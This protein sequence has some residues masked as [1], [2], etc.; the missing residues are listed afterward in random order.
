MR[1]SGDSRIRC[2]ANKIQEME[3][4]LNIISEQSLL[5]IVI[6]QDNVMKYANRAIAEI[7]GFSREEIMEWKPGEYINYIHPD[8][9]EFVLN[10]ALKKQA[11]EKE[12]VTHY[13]YRV[14]TKSDEMKWVD[15][16]SK[17]I[18]FQ[19]RLADFV[20]IT[21]ISEHKRADEELRASEE[22][23]RQIIDGATEIILSVDKEGKI[24]AWNDALVDTTGFTKK[25]MIE[26]NILSQDF[27]EEISSLSE[28]IR[29]SLTGQKSEIYEHKI[30]D[31]SNNIRFVLSQT[32]IIKNSDNKM[33]GVLL[34]GRDISG[35]RKIFENFE[36]GKPYAAIEQPLDEVAEIFN[37]F[38][39]RGYSLLCFSRQNL[40][41][42]LSEKSEMIILSENKNGDIQTEYRP[43]EILNRVKSTI[44][45]KK[46]AILFN[47]IEYISNRYD[48]KTLMRFL[49]KLND[50]I[51][52]TEIILLLNVCKDCF[53]NYEIAL[54]RQEFIAF[55]ETEE[56]ELFLD[57]RKIDILKYL[58][59]QSEFHFN[60]QY[61]TISSQFNLSRMTTKKWIDELQMKGLVQIRKEGRAKYIF[62]S[63]KGREFLSSHRS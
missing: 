2:D 12:V 11:G 30:R 33:R 15:Q 19:G 44:S 13:A 32:S 53:S 39:R 14:M 24:I 59:N 51:R 48:F 54:I 38:S 1:E 9:R 55:P 63:E 29:K 57:P 10:Q 46:T 49:Y 37:N 56:K 25:E 36:N 40:G 8:D 16:Y 6:I 35:Q 45:K 5:G 23:L 21:D 4:K 18:L 42:K 34:I 41:H 7:V 43:Q 50:T 47:N 26:R 58:L 20:T 31:K 60:I 27:P 62:I 52:N 3:E 17:T 61:S 22:R 28:V